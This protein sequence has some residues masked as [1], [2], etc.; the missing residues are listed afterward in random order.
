GAA[1]I[2]VAGGPTP[3]PG[4]TPTPTPA[5]T[6]TPTPA[7][8]PTPTP[9]ATPTPTPAPT[10]T[11]TSTPTPTPTPTPSPAQALNIS[12]RMRVGTG[13]NVLI[14]GFIITGTAPKNVAV[15]GIGPSLGAFGV[16]DTLTDPTL[17]L[18]GSN[19]TLMLA[20]DDWQSDPTQ[21]AQLSALGLGLQDQ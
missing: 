21:A 16:P 1:F 8:T 2:D 18:R 6:P 17:E 19:G 4:V 14:G 20:N 15:R 12:T 13:N 9:T 10:S 3:T 5:A 11:P 7:A